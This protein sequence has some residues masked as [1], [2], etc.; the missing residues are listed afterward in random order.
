MH[1]KG[2]IVLIGKFM[3]SCVGC[4]VLLVEFV[5]AVICFGYLL[6]LLGNRD[7]LRDQVLFEMIMLILFVQGIRDRF[8]FLEFLE[9]VWW[10]MIVLN[11]LCVAEVGDYFF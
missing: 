1:Y 5:D 6:V 2:F 3:G 10:W 9:G 8:C 11:V 4:Y 7:K